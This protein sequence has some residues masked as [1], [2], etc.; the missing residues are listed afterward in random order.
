MSKKIDYQKLEKQLKL[1]KKSCWEV[2]DDKIKKNA[3][4]FAEGYKNFVSEAKTEREAVEEGIKLAKENGFKNIKEIKSLSVGDKV[5]AVNRDKSLFLAKIG[6]KGLE[7]GMKIIMSHI[8]SPHLDFKVNPLYEEENLVFAKTHYYGGIKKYQWPTVSLAL[9]GVVYLENGKKVN[10]KIGE[11][12][13]EPIFMITDL[14]PHLDR[15]VSGGKSEFHEIK[16]EEL[17][18]LLGSLPVNDKKV[19]EKVK[20]AILEY[21]FNKYGIKEEDFVS[22]EIQAVPSEKARDLGFD[23]SLISAYGHDD[24]VCAYSSL[25]S[26][27]DAKI[28]DQT[29]ICILIDREEIGSDGNTGSQSLFIE[30]FLLNILKLNKS[31]SSLEEI[32]NSYSLSQAI[33]ADV[34]VALDPDYKNFVELKNVCKMGFGLAIEK[35]T[36]HGGKY[37]TSEASAEFLQKLKNIFKQDKNIVYQFSGG[38]GGKVDQSGGGTIAKYLAN[39][40]IDVVDIGVALFNMH[41]PLEIVSKADIYCAYLGYKAFLIS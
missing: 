5:Y 35:H 10:I 4:D 22:A 36:G 34:T 30:N 17:N 18:L 28:V 27:L 39:R 15:N 1:E 29:Q 38:L 26:F 11:K 3:F 40:N 21:L 6:K 2:W 8:D 33:S 31:K 16:G 20:L 13:D 37:S 19:K 14:L 41:A 7:K 12:I 23:R 25:M 9:Y 24:K 32:Y